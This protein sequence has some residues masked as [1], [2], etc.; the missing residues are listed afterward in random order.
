MNV[1]LKGFETRRFD[2]YANYP[3]DD[4]SILLKTRRLNL[5]T[6]FRITA[7]ELGILITWCY[8][9]PY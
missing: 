2:Q 6:L 8:G 9:K 4:Q 7:T 5:M 1:E 3:G